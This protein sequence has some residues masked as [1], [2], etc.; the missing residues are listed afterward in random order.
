MVVRT[1]QQ[2]CLCKT[3]SKVIVATDDER[4]AEACRQE[5]A[6]VI[7]TSVSCANGAARPSAEGM[8]GPDAQA[9]PYKPDLKATWLQQGLRGLGGT[10]WLVRTTVIITS[11]ASVAGTERCHEAVT[12][13]P[14]EYDIVINIQGDEPLID[15]HVIDNVVKALQESPDSVYRSEYRLQDSAS[16]CHELLLAECLLAVL[17][18]PLQPLKTLET[19]STRHR[20]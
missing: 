4:I 12:M 9:A 14:G 17:S 10:A 18:G 16:Q 11:A 6:E 3:L 7:M 19:P 1:W 13:M 8:H 2:A 20:I 15:P 5:G